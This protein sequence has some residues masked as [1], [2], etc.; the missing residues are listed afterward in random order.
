[1]YNGTICK[2]SWSFVDVGHKYFSKTINLNRNESLK[3]TSPSYVVEGTFLDHNKHF[4]FQ[5]NFIHKQ[6]KYDYQYLKTISI[7]FTFQNL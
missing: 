3:G 7:F 6:I 4:Y 5:I 2:I 1:M